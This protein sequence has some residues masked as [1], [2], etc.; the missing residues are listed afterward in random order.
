KEAVLEN[1]QVMAGGK[2][3]KV[4]LATD[5]E[6]A[7]NSTISYRIKDQ[8]PGRWLVFRAVNADGSTADALPADAAVTVNVKK[9][10]PSAEGPLKTTADQIF[11]F[12]TYGPFK[13]VEAVCRYRGSKECT[14][15]DSWIITLTNPIDTSK[16]KPSMVQIQPAVEGA[17]IYPSGK[18]I[19]I[20]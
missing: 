19:Y 4:R 14:P 18:N 6:I 15:T 3:V 8:Q 17:S 2:K 11:N 12:R 9:G 7:S 16:F 20:S 13:L 10:T 1:I 5:D